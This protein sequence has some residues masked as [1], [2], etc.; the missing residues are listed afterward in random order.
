M[1]GSS[2]APDIPFDIDRI[3]QRQAKFEGYVSTSYHVKNREGLYLAVQVLLPKGL[4]ENQKVT[5]VLHQTRY[6]R[7]YKYRFPFSLFMKAPYDPKIAKVITTHGYAFVIVDVRG[8]GASGGTSS[9]PF[10]PP[11]IEDGRDIMD[12]IIG[13]PWSN[14]HVVAYGNSY[15]GTTAELAVS[16]RHPAFKGTV[17]RHGP[18]DFYDM[19]F[20]GG[21]PNTRFI[22]NWSALGHALDQ[23]SGKGLKVCIAFDKFIGS[24]GPVAVT[25]VL[26]VDE[27]TRHL[28]LK[29]AADTHKVNLYPIDYFGKVEHRDDQIGDDGPSFDQI[30]VF[31]RK[32]EIEAAGV[33]MYCLGSWLDSNTATNVIVR[34][35]HYDVP[36][37][38]VIGDWDHKAFHKANPFFSHKTKPFLSRE[39]QVID[40]ILFFD[41]C[42]EGGIQ[43]RKELYYF[44]MGEEKW[45]RTT[46]WPLPGTSVEPWYFGGNGVLS[47]DAPAS[48]GSDTCKVD[49]EEG[50]GIRNRWYTLLS[51]P[52]HYPDLSERDKRLI[53]YT[54]E[55]IASEM[56]ITGH[57]VVTFFLRT[58]CDD[59]IAIAYFE[60]VD[61]EGVTHYVTEGQLRLKHRKLSENK[62]YKTPYP[63]HSC[64]REDVLPVVPGE[65]ME[66]VFGMYPVSI[67]IP[68]G[69]R[70]RVAL[71]GADKDSFDRSPA[72]GDPVWTVERGKDTPSRI[73]LPV[74]PRKV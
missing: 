65:R 51:V 67:V 11:E 43:R 40:W 25:G 28:T 74:I 42:I 27:A 53:A 23:T 3:T 36:M 70:L 45:K 44:T 9:Y 22:S 5:S 55:P 69:S 58:T 63:F 49:F 34:F 47:K 32:Q 1:A 41:A 66:L 13:Q 26:P 50:T 20:P 57:P 10:S 37:K 2:I 30:G 15:S 14:G 16:L 73:D 7:A 29:E 35:L 48:G 61:A 33:P 18:W 24:L 38:A 6:W 71:S 21:I 12:W 72:A 8:T 60:F 62:I 56:E 17:T 54:S 52:V 31:A 4:P 39:N 64:R 19:V 68:A 59:G 46:T